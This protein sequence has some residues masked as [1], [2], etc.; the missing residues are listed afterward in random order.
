M[1]YGTRATTASFE[2]VSSVLDAVVLSDT[3]SQIGKR[4]N[5]RAHARHAASIAIE[6]MSDLSMSAWGEVGSV[7]TESTVSEAVEQTDFPAVVQNLVETDG[8][9]RS[10]SS[11]L[12]R[13]H[14]N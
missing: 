11:S 1:I 13:L 4:E 3:I 5:V 12:L 6:V 2:K 7:E 9:I 8:F 10:L 14:L